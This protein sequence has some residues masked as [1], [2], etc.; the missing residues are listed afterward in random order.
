MSDQ[1]FI[2]YYKDNYLDTNIVRLCNIENKARNNNKEGKLFMP[3]PTYGVEDFVTSKIDS[4]IKRTVGMRQIV[5]SMC[6]FVGEIDATGTPVPKMI[7]WD[8]VFS[9]VEMRNLHNFVKV[10]LIDF[11]Q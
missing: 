8:T 5:S 6:S 1:E 7:S 2:D 3:L 10:S 9:Q 11:I 4:D